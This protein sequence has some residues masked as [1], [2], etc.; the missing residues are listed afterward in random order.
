MIFDC[1]RPPQSRA[2]RRATPLSDDGV[3]CRAMARVEFTRNLMKHVTCPPAEVSAPTVRAALDAVFAENAQLK[4]YILDDQDR[5]R[6]HVTI[7]LNGEMIRERTSLAQELKPDDKIFV[8][9][10]LSGG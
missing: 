4:S 1:R 2:P 5:L 10:A 8:F 7:F 6:K 9:Q 3:A